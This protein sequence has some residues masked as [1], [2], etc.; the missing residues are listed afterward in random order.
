MTDTVLRA[1]INHPFNSYSFIGHLFCLVFLLPCMQPFL[2]WF[3]CADSS[4][5]HFLISLS[6]SFLN[7]VEPWGSD[8]DFFCFLYT[9]SPLVTSPNIMALNTLLDF[10]PGSP[11]VKT[12][13]F[14]CRGHG[15][16]PW[17]GNW[18]PLC[19]TVRPKNKKELVV[20]G[21][22]WRGRQE[23]ETLKMQ[24]SPG[25]IVWGSQWTQ[26]AG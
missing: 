3:F 6:L 12:L 13:C 18:D 1:Y 22:S 17:S 20:S 14:Q 25:L 4:L 11:V 26:W 8:L 16:N 15:F 5:S 24:G 23:G 21:R 9:L 7:I 19:C 10:F 2:S